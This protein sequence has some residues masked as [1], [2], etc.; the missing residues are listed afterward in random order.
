M[1]GYQPGGDLEVIVQ[2]L[3]G[4]VVHTD[5]E[6]A[7]ETGSMEVRGPKDFTINLSPFSGG[8]RARFTIAHELGHYIM[9]SRQGQ[10][11]LQIMRDGT[12]R[13]EWEANWFAAGFLMPREFFLERAKAGFGDAELA[14][15]FDVSEAA[16]QLRR[17][18]V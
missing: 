2:R 18:S 3:G 12:G 5:W 11:P 10:I 15:Y 1:V 9:H 14:E 17:T 13:V 8:R 7:R 16:V 6:S 4:K